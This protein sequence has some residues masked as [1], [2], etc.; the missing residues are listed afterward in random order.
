MNKQIMIALLAL[1]TIL[2]AC[3]NQKEMDDLAKAQQCLDKVPASNPSAADSCLAYTSGYND[4]RSNLLNCSIYL[5]SGGI[6]ADRMALAYKASTDSTLTN[7]EADYIGYLAL[8]VPDA[9]S[10]YAKAKLAATYCKASS[11]P[12]LIFVSSLAIAGSFIGTQTSLDFTSPTSLQTGVQTVLTSCQTT[13]ANC[14][15]TVIGPAVVTAAAAY[16][17][18]ATANTSVCATINQSIA[19][20]PGNDTA[21]T[22]GLMCLLGNKTWNS[23]TQTCS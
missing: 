6:T 18:S 9:T 7:P 3:Q 17:A 15:P 4:L 11:D 22:A 23:S 14:D 1:A 21:I 2:S 16:C 20:N 5:T 8:T 13:P 19:G 12:G 10:G